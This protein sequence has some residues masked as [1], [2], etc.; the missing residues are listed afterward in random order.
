M[1]S[2]FRY[3]ICYK[4]VVLVLKTLKNKSRKKHGNV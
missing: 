1:Y 4:L 3:N 2:I